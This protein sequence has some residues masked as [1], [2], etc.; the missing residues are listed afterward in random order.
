MC[1]SYCM[2]QQWLYW[3]HDDCHPVICPVA[4]QTHGHCETCRHRHDGRCGLT[5]APLP[6]SGGCCHHN[7][8]LV[9]EEQ[10]VTRVM[11]EPLGITIDETDIFILLR[12][13]VSYQLKPDGSAWIEISSLAMPFTYGLGTDHLP[14]EILD[15]SRW[16]QQWQQCVMEE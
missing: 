12:E 3:N 4:T 5:A 13:N 6:K 10:E 16:F 8:T 14:D 1:I 11:L 7:V 2:R 15:W 9:E